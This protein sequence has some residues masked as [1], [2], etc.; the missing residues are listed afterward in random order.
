MQNHAGSE[1]SARFRSPREVSAPSLELA[2]EVLEHG[3]M[4]IPQSTEKDVES[5]WQTGI[6]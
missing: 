2:L 3:S 6:H 1:Q 5:P 4:Q